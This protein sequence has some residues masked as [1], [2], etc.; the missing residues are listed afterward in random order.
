M[1]ILFILSAQ[2]NSCFYVYTIDGKKHLLRVGPSYR[3]GDDTLGNIYYRLSNVYDI[4]MIIEENFSL[5]IDRIVVLP[6]NQ[7]RKFLFATNRTI[8]VRNPK[9]F[10]FHRVQENFPPSLLE[11][12]KF[13]KGSLVLDENSFLRFIT[14]QEDLPGVYGIFERQEHILRLIKEELFDSLNPIKLTK[15]FNEFKQVVDTDLSIKDVIQLASLYKDS[16]GRKTARD[17]LV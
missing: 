7:L 17:T 14:Y 12:E 10:T 16:K 4:K 2:D 11:M 9:A 5:K 15:R 3:I 8:S 6:V 13:P 1:T